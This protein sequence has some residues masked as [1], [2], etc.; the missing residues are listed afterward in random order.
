V[1]DAGL[2]ELARLKSLKEL[3]LFKTHV[4]DAGLKEL[5]GLMSL[6]FLDL[7]KTKVTDAGLR[8][9][10]KALPECEIRF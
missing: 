1:T 5:A 3:S 9:L 7:R 2:K 6:Q 8:E 4:T 10:H